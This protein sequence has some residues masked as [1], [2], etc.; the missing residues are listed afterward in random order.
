MAASEIQRN[1]AAKRE[2]NDQLASS[3]AQLHYMGD[4]NLREQIRN[5]AAH[6]K[7]W[8]LRSEEAP[9]LLVKEFPAEELMKKLNP[10][11]QTINVLE[12]GS[13]EMSVKVLQGTTTDK[14]VIYDTVEAVIDGTFKAV[15]YHKDTK[16][17]EAY[18]TFP[19]NGANK[20][21]CLEGISCISSENTYTSKELKI[22]F[23]PYKL[24]AIEK[25]KI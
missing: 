11:I 18:F 20:N 16:L 1:N 25:L 4:M 17:G 5:V 7:T 14:L 19:Y 8:E 22:Q 21:T 12:T 15:I 10:Q 6:T 13:V 9:N 3:I 23:E 24:W 2:R